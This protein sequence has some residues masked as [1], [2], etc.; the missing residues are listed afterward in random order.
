MERM[1]NVGHFF[2]GTTAA[3]DIIHLAAGTTSKAPLR[4]TSGSL[5]TGGNIRV[6]QFQFLTDKFYGT[7]TTSTA[8]KEFTLNDIAL[9]SGRVP[10]ATTNGRLT[11]DADFTFATDTLTVTKIAATTYTGTQT[12]ANAIN[13]VFNTT[14]GTKIGT[15]T[16]QKIGFWNAAPVVQPAGVADATG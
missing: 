4:L 16:T 9:T 10:F 11:D 6:G 5:T 1:N 3:T 15:G 8:V 13:L 12:Y 2:G 14:T 7:I